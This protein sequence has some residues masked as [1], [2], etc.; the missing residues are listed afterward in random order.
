MYAHGATTSDS[1]C[2]DSLNNI[3]VLCLGHRRDAAVLPATRDVRRHGEQTH[4]RAGRGEQAVCGQPGRGRVV[5]V[6]YAGGAGEGGGGGFG[7]SHQYGYHVRS[8]Y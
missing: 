7:G 1:L 6:Y 3:F 8:S 2:R 5:G 4:V